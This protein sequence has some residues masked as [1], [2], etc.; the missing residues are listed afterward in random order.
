[1]DGASIFP[2]AAAGARVKLDEHPAILQQCA[3]TS[4]D[5]S[6]IATGSNETAPAAALDSK[7]LDVV[8]RW[9]TAVSGWRHQ[10]VGEQFLVLDKA[11]QTVLIRN[12]SNRMPLGL[13]VGIAKVHYDFNCP[14]PAVSGTT[15][16]CSTRT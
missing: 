2:I 6:S 11:I 13:G 10:P 3:K 15:T 7:K 14:L 9:D 16:S 5:V 1:M 12:Y 4:D 8:E